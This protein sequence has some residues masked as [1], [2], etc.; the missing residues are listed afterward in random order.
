[1]DLSHSH[2]PKK[3]RVPYE[4]HEI[5]GC[6]I[7]ILILVY[8]NDNAHITG[9]DFNPNKSPKQPG[10]PS[11]SLLTL[12]NMIGFLYGTSSAQGLE[13]SICDLPGLKQGAHNEALAAG[14]W[15]FLMVHE[16]REHAM[17]PQQPVLEVG[18]KNSTY[19]GYNVITPVIHLVSAIYRP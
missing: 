7:G 14:R 18:W 11:F 9:P 1:M 8:Y 12:S 17:G 4:I 6:L 13:V 3:K 19:R 2:G 10:D 5:P 16:T 15:F